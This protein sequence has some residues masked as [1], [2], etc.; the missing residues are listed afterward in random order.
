[1]RNAQE[2]NLNQ[3]ALNFEK[4][5]QKKKIYKYVSLLL[6]ELLLIFILFILVTLEVS[7]NGEILGLLQLIDLLKQLRFLFIL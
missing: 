1:M 6:V 7:S 4:R 3:K 5:Q 2:N